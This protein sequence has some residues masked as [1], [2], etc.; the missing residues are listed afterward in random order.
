MCSLLFVTHS[1][2]FAIKWIFGNVLRY[3]PPLGFG[4]LR[5][6]VL[7]SV[8]LNVLSADAMVVNW[9]L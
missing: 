5:I 1:P 6:P 2:K 9:T 8:S 4:N 3:L 7:T